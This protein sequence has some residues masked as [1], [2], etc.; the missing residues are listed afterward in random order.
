MSIILKEAIACNLIDSVST[1]YL[2]SFVVTFLRPF[3]VNSLFEFNTVCNGILPL[4]RFCFPKRKFEE[5]GNITTPSIRAPLYGPMIVRGFDW[6]PPYLERNCFLF[7]QEP[8]LKFNMLS[9]KRSYV[10]INYCIWL[11]FAL[12]LTFL[13]IHNYTLVFYQVGDLF[14]L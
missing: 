7:V 1:M 5:P 2:L 3:I 4:P 10:N 6:A 13:I 12:P 14:A 11:P 9:S 8:K